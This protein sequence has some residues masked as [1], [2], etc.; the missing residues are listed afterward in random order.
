MTRLATEPFVTEAVATGSS[1]EMALGEKLT[2]L[3]GEDID[4]GILGEIWGDVVPES[5]YSS[6]HVESFDTNTLSTWASN[7]AYEGARKAFYATAG[8][9]PYH[10]Q[11]SDWGPFDDQARLE[12]DFMWAVN[13]G[14]SLSFVKTGTDHRLGF[15]LNEIGGTTYRLKA[16][17]GDSFSTTDIRTDIVIPGNKEIRLRVTRNGNSL[18]YQ[19]YNLTDNVEIVADTFAIPAPALAE[20]GAG[21]NLGDI[22]FDGSNASTGVWVDEVRA[23]VEMLEQRD[24]WIS[25]HPADGGDVVTKRLLG[26]MGGTTIRSDFL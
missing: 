18:E 15:N 11:R 5:G 16:F 23:L 7:F 9:G 19:V 17:H 25:I 8:G 13:G 12:M 24:I 14:A 2:F 21:Q 22:Y 10:G 6:T 1:G 3:L 4:S 26:T 20:L